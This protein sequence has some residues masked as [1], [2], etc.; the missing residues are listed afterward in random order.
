[1]VAKA[2]RGCSGGG[3]RTRNS[4]ASPAAIAFG[5]VHCTQPAGVWRRRF[6]PAMT[7]SLRFTLMSIVLG[8]GSLVVATLAEAVDEAI[9][10]GPWMA[11][12][13]A[14]GV[15]A[16]VAAVKGA[17]M[18]TS[19]R[20]GNSVQERTSRA[21]EAASRMST[22]ATGGRWKTPRRRPRR[23][24]ASSSTA[25]KRLLSP[26]GLERWSFERRGGCRRDA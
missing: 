16:T 12:G 15:E 23:W 10:A 9:D 17:G 20:F 25:Q 2:G 6:C 11:V 8:P 7:A 18:T 21:S 13:G 14:T 1:M 4:R 22:N 5:A 19:S 3:A 26:Q 24:A